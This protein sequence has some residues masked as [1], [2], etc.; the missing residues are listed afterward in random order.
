MEIGIVIICVREINYNSDSVET[1]IVILN[2][3]VIFYLTE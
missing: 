2:I 1:E 3:S